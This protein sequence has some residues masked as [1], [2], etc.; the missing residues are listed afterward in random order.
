MFFWYI[1]CISKLIIPSRE[2]H[3]PLLK[4][5]SIVCVIITRLTQSI[6]ASLETLATMKRGLTIN[7]RLKSIVE[8]S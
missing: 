8:M 5:W 2:K 6:C 3:I 4:K 7:F 1:L